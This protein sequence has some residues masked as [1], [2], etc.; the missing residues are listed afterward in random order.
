MESDG[1]EYAKKS[2]EMWFIILYTQFIALKIFF[3]V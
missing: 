3:Y 1:R 2:S